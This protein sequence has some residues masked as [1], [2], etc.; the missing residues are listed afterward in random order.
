MLHAPT[1]DLPESGTSEGARY[2][3]LLFRVA[4]PS[5]LVVL[6]HCKKVFAKASFCILPTGE[7]AMSL[8]AAAVLLLLK[9]LI[10]ALL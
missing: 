5:R 8:F 7:F 3:R 2:I 10:H 4:T 9:L 6:A 1:A